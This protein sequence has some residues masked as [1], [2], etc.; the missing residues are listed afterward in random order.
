V[1]RVFNAQSWKNEIISPWSQKIIDQKFYNIKYNIVFILNLQLRRTFL[2]VP[3]C[4][5]P[6]GS[7]RTHLLGPITTCYPADLVPEVFWTDASLPPLATEL[8]PGPLEQYFPLYVSRYNYLRAFAPVRFAGKGMPDYP[9][10]FDSYPELHQFAPSSLSCLLCLDLARRT[11]A[12][13]RR[14]SPKLSWGPKVVKELSCRV[15]R[16]MS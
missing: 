4:W 13:V 14:M 2:Q 5:F 10:L 7:S 11:M 15:V 8:I 12:P 3:Y 9:L 16:G 1:P 6:Q